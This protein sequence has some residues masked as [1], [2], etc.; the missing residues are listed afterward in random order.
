MNYHIFE[1]SGEKAK[2]LTL[3]KRRAGKFTVLQTISDVGFDIGKWFRV[4]MYIA[5]N[6]FKINFYEV[7]TQPQDNFGDVEDDDE[8]QSGT[9]GFS[10]FGTS[11]GF[12][13]I[14]FHP[15]GDLPV[16]G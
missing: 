1:I 13:K 14:F 16:D 8:E 9:I 11:A 5:G 3:K 12:D 7:D 6:K 10:T 2:S 15:I 4:V